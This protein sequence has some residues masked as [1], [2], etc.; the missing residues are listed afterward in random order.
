MSVLGGPRCSR[1]RGAGMNPAA[2]SHPPSRC[3]GKQVTSSSRHGSDAG[4]AQLS[5]APPGCWEQPAAASSAFGDCGRRISSGAGLR[6][7]AIPGRWQW[8]DQP[9]LPFSSPRWALG[10]LAAL[11]G[12]LP[13]S[14]KKL[15]APGV[16]PLSQGS[17]AGWHQPVQCQDPAFP[18]GTP[19]SQG[20]CG[21]AGGRDAAS[22][23]LHSD[24]REGGERGNFPDSFP[25]LKGKK[26][27]R[28]RMT[29]SFPR[30]SAGR[31]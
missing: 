14:P 12:A 24:Q 16:A 27:R 25:H 7:T 18:C 10:V 17:C 21:A 8:G 19:G 13:S 2:P 9:P 15:I 1:G 29:W 31:E 6:G 28:S 22:T 5:G 26:K 30:G 20:R 11:A 23:C 3:V 4:G